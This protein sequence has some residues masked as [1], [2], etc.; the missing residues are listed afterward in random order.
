MSYEA[1]IPVSTY[2]L[3][4]N[5][6]FT[7]RDARE[8]IRYLSALGITDIYASPYF[9]AQQGS[10]HGYD[11]V[12]PNALNPEVG[13]EEEYDEL[14]NELRKNGMGQI[15][16]IVP[17]HMCITST[18]NIRWL[19]ILENGPG[20]VYADF[21]DINWYPVKKELADKVLLPFL[22]AQY[23][24]VLERQELALVFEEGSFFIN[25]SGH[26]FPLTPKTYAD[27][28]GRRIGELE[29]TLT[30]AAPA[31]MELLSII[32]ALNNLPSYTEKDSARISE[33]YREKEIIKRRLREL[34]EQSPGIRAFINENVTLF[35]GSKGAPRSFDA[36]DALLNRQ[37]HRLSYWRVATDEINYRRF[38]DINQ[39]A[40]VKMEGAA[41]YRETHALIFR[42][43]EEGKVT[44]FRVDHPD[45]LYDPAEY[46][47]W[48]QRDS[49]LRMNLG[50]MRRLKGHMDLPA[51]IEAGILEQYE[52]LLLSEPDFKPFYI[53][54]EK[55]L[56]R[57][58]K[59]P[60]NWPIF[61]TTGYVFMNSLNGIF[62]DI[63][64]A[65]EF[66][67]MYSK[68]IGAK[69]L[70]PDTV[71][72]KKKLIMQVAMSSEIN[73]LG[74]YLN[75]LSE[76]DRQTRD[77]TL[78]SLTCAIVEVIAFFPVYRTYIDASGVSDTDRRYIE[79]AVAK[80]KRKNPAISGN[81]YDFLMD[82]LMLRYPENI[83]EDARREWFSF[84][85][86][87]QQVTG[88]VMAKGLEDTAF[89]VYNRFISLNEVGGSPDR[90][91]TPLETF[92]GQNIERNKFWPHAL[93]TTST[94]D[95]K[96]GEDVRARI[97]VL[98]EIPGE[99]RRRLIRW[100]RFNK[101]KKP[102]VEGQPVPGANEEYLLYQTLAGAWPI[103]GAGAAEYDDFK[104]RIKDYMLKAVR[105]AKVNSSWINSNRAYE[106]AFMAFIE[107]LLEKTHGN[108]FLM[109][110]EEFHERISSCGMF[111][112]LSQVLLK[113][114]SPGVPD[115][116]QGNEVWNFSLV[117]PDNRRQVDYSIRAGMLDELRK[118]EAVTALKELAGELFAKKSDG[119]VKLYLTYKALNFRRDRRELFER[120]EYIALEAGGE[121]ADNICSFAKRLNG[122][123]LVIIAARFFT[124]LI[125]QPGDLPLGRKAWG[126][127]YVVLPFE[128]PGSRYRNVF[129]DEIIAVAAGR[130]TAVLYLGEAFAH[131]PAALMER[132]N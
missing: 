4:F 112:S 82:V 1:R 88:P 40:A 59:M 93:I 119:S 2:R 44:G 97:N 81:I 29:R 77:F 99:W 42:L 102:L 5:C 132:V 117:D 115:F 131:F 33:M 46:F 76:R 107:A 23:G 20:S 101:R 78:N 22:G 8:I 83:S 41:V 126:E 87:F 116:Y 61:G 62:I 127:S 21:F 104:T 72:E 32:T 15:L 98:S 63:G 86:K 90:F 49:F 91:G 71:Y 45:G 103:G 56:T 28:L 55:I 121:R 80:A 105:E 51:D 122:F 6:R 60:G 58:E 129:T 95:S 34:C 124:E 92:H 68:F 13:T 73:T 125:Q 74:R 128:R 12:D 7:F 89:Y 39:I 114:A 36:L 66:D 18:D 109:D 67:V 30:G 130:G 106:G 65:E 111:N 11:I 84:V 54:G 123:I 64:S 25:Y 16:D 31:F 37:P 110:F 19:D 26:K 100:R 38:F 52:E 14:I 57:G 96:R 10:L 53:I 17:N 113:I 43:V 47:R 35:N 9:K 75:E 120:G 50:N 108:Q 24:K 85:K 27:V 3:Q 79:L 48:L 118:R 69:M 70:F 94:H